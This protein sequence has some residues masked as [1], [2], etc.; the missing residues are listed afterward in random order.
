MIRLLK[1]AS[2]SLVMLVVMTIALLGFV[3]GTDTGTRLAWSLARGFLPEGMTIRSVEG[4]L[5]GPF[6]VH[7]LKL[8]TQTMCL[9]IDEFEFRLR[10]ARLLEHRLLDIESIVVRGLRYWQTDN[11]PAKEAPRSAKLPERIDL[12]VDV[13][14]AARLHDFEY[15][16]KPTARPLKVSSAALN[17]SFIG[18]RLMIDRLMVDAPFLTLDGAAR[19]T[20]SGAYALK[21]AFD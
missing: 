5:S 13:R 1:F 17:A 4:H 19:L 7:D 6:M 21:G 10:L 2:V 20:T 16:T 8:K 14:V 12:P 3:V 9:R 18:D 15:R 11:G